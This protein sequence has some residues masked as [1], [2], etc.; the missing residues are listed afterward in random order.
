MK[1]L[2]IIGASGHGRV[3][4]EIA[5][6]SN[7]YNEIIFLD[8]DVCLKK[9]GKY[10]VNGVSGDFYRYLNGDTVYFVAIG[11][12]NHRKRIMNEIKN[13][14]GVFAVLIH[15]GAIV[16][17]GVECGNGSVIMPGAVVNT[18]TVIGEGVIINTSSSVDH[19]CVIGAWSHIAVG[20]HLC[21]TVVV[22]VK[23]WIGAGAV[24][25]N[26]ISI[27]SETVVGAGTVVVDDIH[28]PG[29]YIG[30]P[31]RPMVRK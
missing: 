30:V 13:A 29:T 24:I 14:G 19:D 21:G 18:G 11:D 2:V 16:S 6:L 25:S 4:A 27:I 15:P 12:S 1:R 23:C 22:G 5:E 9:S 8:D 28:V 7:K 20:A 17:E 3:C 10:S 31:A 26:N